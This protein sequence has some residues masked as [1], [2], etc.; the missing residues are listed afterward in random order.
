MWF[1]FMLGHYGCCGDYEMDL[2]LFMLWLWW[3]VDC[4]Y[5]NKLTME[6]LLMMNIM[7]VVI[8]TVDVKKALVVATVLVMVPFFWCCS[9]LNAC[10]RTLVTFPSLLL[11]HHLS[12]DGIACDIYLRPPA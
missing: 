8:A 12:T 11:S 3:F 6:M 9:T 5:W 10:R 7:V 4:R 1:A 2:M